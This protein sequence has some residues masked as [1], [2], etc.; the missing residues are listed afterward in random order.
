MPCSHDKRWLQLL[1]PFRHWRPKART[2]THSSLKNALLQGIWQVCG[3]AFLRATERFTDF[4]PLSL[5]RGC[6]VTSSQSTC[7]FSLWM[8]AVGA[9]M[10]LSFRE[11]LGP[12]PMRQALFS[13]D[14]HTPFATSQQA[15]ITR[16]LAGSLTNRREWPTGAWS[17]G[18]WALRALRHS[19]E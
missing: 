7:L 4:S 17:E 18:A 2:L 16:W 8:V 1:L 6:D 9:R 15:P 10:W 11:S 14:T 13:G 3:E 12:V 5:S 19:S